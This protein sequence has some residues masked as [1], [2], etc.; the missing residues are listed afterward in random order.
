MKPAARTRRRVALAALL[1]VGLGACGRRGDLELPGT[2]R[3]RQQDD[4]TQPTVPSSPGGGGDVNGADGSAP[5]GG[6]PAS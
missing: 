3:R 1:A 6:G 4:P 2:E 5:T